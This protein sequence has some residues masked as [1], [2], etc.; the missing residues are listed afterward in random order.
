[1]EIVYLWIEDYGSIKKQGINLNGKYRINYSEGILNARRAPNYP[2]LFFKIGDMPNFKISN[3]TAVVGGNGSGKTTLLEFIKYHLGYI[4]DKKFKQPLLIITKESERLYY[5]KFGIDEVKVTGDVEIIEGVL[6]EIPSEIQIEEYD[7]YE[8]SKY[9]IPELLNSKIIYFSNVFDEN[10]TIRDFSYD[11]DDIFLDISSNSLVLHDYDMSKDRYQKNE[12]LRQIR[13]L[14]S[15]LAGMLFSRVPDLLLIDTF[16]SLHNFDKEMNKFGLRKSFIHSLQRKIV[17]DLVDG[18]KYFTESIRNILLLSILDYVSVS[19]GEQLMKD[20][21]K[22]LEMELDTLIFDNFEKSTIEFLNVI[23]N[24][25][26]SVLN[27]GGSNAR[28]PE[29]GRLDSTDYA[30]IF[31]NRTSLVHTLHQMSSFVVKYDRNRVAISLTESALIDNLLTYYFGSRFVDKILSIELS[32]LS[33][34][35]SAM[36]QTY[37]RFYWLIDRYMNEQ[38][39]RTYGFTDSGFD[40]SHYMLKENLIILIDEG[41]VFLH[42]NWQREYIQNIVNLFYELFKNHDSVKQVQVILTSNSP[43]VISDLP[44]E[45]IVLL[46]SHSGLS[47]V[48]DENEKFDT[49]GANIH[50]LLS[51][52]FFM[53]NGVIGEFAKNKLNYVIQLLRGEIDDQNRKE[54]E[55]II[56]IIGEPVIKSKLKEMYDLKYNQSSRLQL[57]EEEISRLQKERDRIL[58]ERED[59]ND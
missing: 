50:M 16:Y 3:I 56:N 20:R 33:S 29:S 58:N 6:K 59:M 52:T 42:P 55:Y 9:I 51:N 15:P 10:K 23:K 7:Y 14:Q 24:R 1:M 19:T 8:P 53:K 47:R 2:D 32:G 18:N 22:E 21:N 38:T 5:Y 17:P 46:E 40:V 36:L 34:G 25:I 41:E 12:V 37:A 31:D 43:F 39:Y 49:F 35:E 11:F 26:C 54:V 57:L 30:L 48:L 13:F 28:A 45:N 27:E 4:E 44:K